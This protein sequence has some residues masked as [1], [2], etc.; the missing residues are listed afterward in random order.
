M[1]RTSHI[2]ILFFTLVLQT[3]LSAQETPAVI[4][5]FTSQGCSSC[6]P[7]DAILEQIK[8][9]FGDDVITLSYHVD[10][11]DYIGWKDPFATK[12]FT[13]KQYDYAE[14]FKSRS[15]YTPQ[16]VIN[17]RTHHTGSDKPSIYRALDSKNESI[18]AIDLTITKTQQ[19]G[20]AISVD[21]SI[22][23]TRTANQLT[24]VIAI[25]Q[26]ITQVKRGENRNKTLKNT[27]IVVAE[28]TIH[29]YTS[30]GQIE[31]K[32]PDWIK[33]QD[34]LSVVA[35]ATKNQ[36]GIIDAVTKRL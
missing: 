12:G 31:L 5:L 26:K 30:N 7:A 3:E 25:D 18:K 6:P 17:G 23:D 4:E 32:L 36:V 27:H 33:D 10:Y 20:N 2:L 24:F 29:Q 11:W 34:Q 13:Q 22:S 1:M 15:V 8:N 28:Q 35:Y 16:A 21:Y 9:E 19:K 14:K